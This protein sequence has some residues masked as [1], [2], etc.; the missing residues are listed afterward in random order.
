MS[1]LSKSERTQISSILTCRSNEIAHYKDANRDKFPD[2]VGSALT[3]EIQ[4]LRELADKVNPPEKE[5]EE[6]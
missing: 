1:E 5:E 2:S 6:E 3:R 4:R